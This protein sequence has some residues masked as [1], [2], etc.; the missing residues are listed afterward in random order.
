MASIYIHIPFCK[1]KCIYCNFYFSTSMDSKD[2]IVECLKKEIESRANYLHNKKIKSIYF[3]GGTPSILESKDINSILNYIYKHY[4]L[5]EN[6]EIT[7]ECNPDD[8]NFEKLISLKKNGINRLSIG[9]QSLNDKDLKFMNRNHS[10]SQSK[11][12]IF[13]AKKIGFNNISVDLIYGIPSQNLNSWKNTLLTILKLEIQHISAYA[14]TIEKNTQLYHL[15]KKKKVNELNEKKFLRLYDELI[16][17]TKKN[18]FIQYEISNFGKKDF[19]SNHNIGY[20]TGNHYLGIGPSSHS[21]NGN[22]R[23]WNVS[24]NKKYIDS[25]KKNNY[26]YKTETLSIKEKYNEYVFTSLRTIWGVN[27]SYIEKKFGGKFKDYFYNEVQRWSNHI[28]M[29]NKKNTYILND[30]GKKIADKIAADLFAV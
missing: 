27:I 2:L 14:L 16:S 22:S 12:A 8:L 24:S 6:I 1:Q 17:F 4:N 11:Q 20:W 19:F 28:I 25:L 3:G 30:E 10:A 26:N 9:L 5:D 13:D 21:F 23:R 15:V 29:L 7:F 18:N